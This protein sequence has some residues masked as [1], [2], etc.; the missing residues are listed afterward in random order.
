MHYAIFVEYFCSGSFDTENII[1]TKN[2]CEK[3]EEIW[4]EPINISLNVTLK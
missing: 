2:S 1:A 3:V 4:D